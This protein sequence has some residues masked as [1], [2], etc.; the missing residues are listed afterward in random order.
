MVP[1]QFVGFQ[2]GLSALD[3]ARMSGCDEIVSFLTAFTSVAIRN[4][5]DM[6]IEPPTS[7]KSKLLQD[8]VDATCRTSV[9]DWDL[10][11]LTHLVRDGS[12]NNAVVRGMECFRMFFSNLCFTVVR[13]PRS[14]SFTRQR[15]DVRH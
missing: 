13:L 8:L 4:V 1:S 14:S 12:E 3:A 7:F 5:K 2:R 9:V 11:V 15:R 6:Y 10:T